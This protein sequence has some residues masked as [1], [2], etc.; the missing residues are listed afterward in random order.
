MN[1]K[2]LFKQTY[3]II[4]TL[5]LPP[6]AVV[7]KNEL[8]Q[9]FP[10]V[11]FW[12]WLAVISSGLL[13]I[14]LV[15]ILYNRPRYYIDTESSCYIDKK[16]NKFCPVCMANGK[17]VLVEERGKYLSCFNFAECHFEKNR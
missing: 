4:L 12:F 17:R 10:K 13:L 2:E 7:F 14:S 16:G 6:L 15:Y 1:L 3:G 5:V 11:E 9:I 8:I